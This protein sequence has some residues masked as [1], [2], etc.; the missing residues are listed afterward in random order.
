VRRRGLGTRKWPKQTSFRVCFRQPPSEC[1]CRSAQS[2]QAAGEVFVE[3]GQGVELRLH[4]G[5]QGENLGLV[6]ALALF[7]EG[8]EG[9]ALT[10]VDLLAEGVALLQ[11]LNV[12]LELLLA[13]VLAALEPAA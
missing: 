1:P 12:E 6:A 8:L 2:F 5:F 9:F 11:D 10:L 3:Q 4:L 7:G 13:L